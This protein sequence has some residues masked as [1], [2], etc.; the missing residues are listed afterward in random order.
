MQI[1]FIH[2]LN[3]I[4]LEFGITVEQDLTKALSLYLKGA[5]L[6]EPYC[7]FRLYYIYKNNPEKFNLEP[8]RDL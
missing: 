8:D 4:N 3:G 6:K 5:A 7:N 2:F 1:N